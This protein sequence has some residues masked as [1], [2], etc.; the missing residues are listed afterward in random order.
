[1]RRR[2]RFGHQV[3]ADGSRPARPDERDSAPET[4]RGVVVDAAFDW[5]DDRQLRTAWHGPVIYE[6]HV[7]GFT[8]QHP[9]VPEELRGT[10]RRA[11]SDPAIEHLQR[12]GVT[13]VELLPVHQHVNDRHLVERGLTQLLGLQHDRLLRARRTTRSRPATASR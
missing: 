13:A 9:D 4:P 2:C 6:V 11:G 8:Q 12:L 10:L 1:M 3:D 5:G 7:K